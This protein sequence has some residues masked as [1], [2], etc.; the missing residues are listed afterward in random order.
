MG[1]LGSTLVFTRS[2]GVPAVM[3]VDARRTGALTTLETSALGDHA[4]HCLAERAVGLVG[5]RGVNTRERDRVHLQ[6]GFVRG[7]EDHRLDHLPRH[8]IVEPGT[9]W[10]VTGRWPFIDGDAEVTTWGMRVR[11]KSMVQSGSICG[12]GAADDRMETGIFVN[13]RFEVQR[14]HN[15][16]ERRGS[17]SSDD[18][19][20]V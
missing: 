9:R 1:A 19:K 15:D 8:H 20:A 14:I 3:R 16:L 11:R 6:D 7:V 17:D 10:D 4:G 2:D 13:Y 5:W 18:T 12:L